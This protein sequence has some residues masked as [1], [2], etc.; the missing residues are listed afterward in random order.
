MA[1]YNLFGLNTVSGIVV[2]DAS[3][4][5]AVLSE[6][7]S[8]RPGDVVISAVDNVDVGENVSIQLIGSDG[9]SQNIEVDNII[10]QIEAGQDPTLDDDQAPA[11][12]DDA[13]SSLTLSAGVQRDGA[14]TIAETMFETQGLIAQGLT[15]TQST[16]LLR[17]FETISIPRVASISTIPDDSITEGDS[18]TFRVTL[19]SETS[20]ATT[21][22][23]TLP[24]SPDVAL[25]DIS[26]S[27]GVTLGDD[28]RLNVPAGVS[29]FDIILPT[30]DDDEVEA[31]EIYTLAVDGVEATGTIL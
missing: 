16:A 11:A 14:E 22:P 31:T 28:G 1:I 4:K 25:A 8:P 30:V 27:N 10:A 24:S 20:I 23:V 9:A 7:A 6:G 19:D 5:L 17:F 26:F 18:F 13:G 15:A 29:A 21:F 12:G 3:G 2:L